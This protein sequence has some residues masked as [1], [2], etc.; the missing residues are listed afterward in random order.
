MAKYTE[1]AAGTYRCR[2]VKLDENFTMT[3]KQ[4][5]EDVT[6]WRWVF[7]EVGDPTTVGEID[8]ISSPGFRPRSNGLKFLMGMLG[9][10][11]PAGFDTDTL[12]GQEFDVQYGPN[13]AG[14]LTIVGVAKP[15]NPTPVAAVSAAH[16]E[17]PGDLPF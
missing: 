17:A 8:T 6:R 13:Q 16:Q 12:I 10:P 14:T 9:G 1:R 7:Q 2:F 3:D 15:S 4:T 11:P 5:G